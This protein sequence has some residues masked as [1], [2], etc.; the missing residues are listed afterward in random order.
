MCG[1]C[2]VGEFLFLGFLDFYVLFG[3]CFFVEDFFFLG[4]LGEEWSGVGFGFWFLGMGDGVVEGVLGV[5]GNGGYID[6]EVS[7]FLLIDYIGFNVGLF[8]F[9]EFF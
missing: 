8:G 3:L 5:V 9:V 6:G 2:G 1:W 7:I 4:C